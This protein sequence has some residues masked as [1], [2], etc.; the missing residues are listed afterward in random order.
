MYAYNIYNSGHPSKI[1]AVTKFSNILL[2][3]FF[4]D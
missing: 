4:S 2:V 3:A 1:F